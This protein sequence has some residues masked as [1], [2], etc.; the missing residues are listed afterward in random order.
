M[1]NR[2][3]RYFDRNQLN[4]LKFLSKGANVV[5]SEGNLFHQI[6]KITIGD[7]VYIGP[8]G[9]YYGYG[10]LSIGSGSILSHKIEILTRNHNYNSA[11]LESIP[12]DKEYLLKSVNIKENVWVG[13]NVLIVPGV[14][15]GEGSV[16]GMGS[17]VTKDVPPYAIVG[18]NPAK[19]L[20][21]R[22]IEKY[23]QLKA[24]NKIYLKMKFKK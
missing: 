11:N 1:I 14:T 5:I 18:G 6:D 10:G 4:N 2:I 15:I 7:N 22:D 24:E 8:N 20:K 3:K 19:V 21:Y 16:V 23:E 13:S 17:V 9:V 12:Y